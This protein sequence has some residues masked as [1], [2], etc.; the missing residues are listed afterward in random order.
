M[1]A[2]TLTVETID[3]PT[4]AGAMEIVKSHMYWSM[5]LG[6][7]PVP[8][9]DFAAVTTTQVMMLRKLSAYYQREFNED[10][11]KAVISSLIGG[12]GSTRLAYGAFGSL[13]K[14]I[15][16][17]GSLAGAL[18]MP[19]MAGAATYALGKVFIL[20]FSSGGTWLNF[21]PAKARAYYEAAYCERLEEAKKSK[22][23]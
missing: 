22:K 4:T 21:D 6:L 7:I 1:T 17:V 2:A 11:G 12:Y 23:A 13:V 8:V 20:H 9:I 19:A 18:S 10:W 15:P 5:G 14:A 3:D 16:L